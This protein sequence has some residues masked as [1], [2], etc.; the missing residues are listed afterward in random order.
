MQQQQKV[1]SYYFVTLRQHDCKLHQKQLRLFRFKSL[2]HS[3]LN[4]IDRY[5]ILFCFFSGT[6]RQYDLTDLR[7][8]TDYSVRYVHFF[9][10]CL[11]YD[12]VRLVSIAAGV[13]L[14]VVTLLLA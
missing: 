4:C 12:L 8:A 3:H 9:R 11:C 6:D 7:P 5:L 13:K 1:E 10:R 14:P 2:I